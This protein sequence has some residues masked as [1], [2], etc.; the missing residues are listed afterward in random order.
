MS[1][2]VLLEAYDR[3]R[4]SGP[5]W[6]ADQLTNHGPMAVEVLVRRGHA[7]QVPAWLDRY[8]RR[9]DE[10]PRAS[11]PIDPD[12]WREALG[13]GRRIGDWTVFFDRELAAAPWQEVLVRWWPRLLP[14]IAAGASH[15]LIRT[16][17]AA[18]ALE[19]TTE[20]PAV[21]ELGRA[22]AFWAA[23][24]LAVPEV[25]EPS[26]TL[27]AHTALAALPRPAPQAG[28]VRD[29]FARLGAMPTW[30][31]ALSDLHGAASASEVPD[32][33]GEIVTAATCAYLQ[34]GPDSPVLL[35]HTATA[36]N[37]V[38]NVLPLL[39][40]E[41]WRPSLAAVW[42]LSAAITAGYAAARPE[43]PAVADTAPDLDAVLDRA[44]SHGDEHV[45][46]FTDCAVDAYVRSNDARTV[47][48]ATRI[49][50]LIAA[51]A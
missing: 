37:A 48:A 2:E 17:H 9:L 6:G 22:L 10:L 49:V 8:M 40:D 11:D 25:R 4:D 31:A 42:S 43:P 28:P 3:L 47:A 12:T 46:K 29:R 23:R 19:R 39:P 1:T 16:A 50:D 33:L 35:V 24:S 27:D 34:S 38:L 5:E 51:P 21:R 30:P 20:E 14:G 44:A 18:R 32:L 45:V 7:Q 36:P 41:L 26:G 15:G 13:D